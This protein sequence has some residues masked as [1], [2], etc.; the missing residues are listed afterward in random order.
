MAVMFMDPKI[1]KIYKIYFDYL[2]KDKTI[3]NV[4]FRF[5]VW[6]GERDQDWELT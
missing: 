3:Y 5:K 6:Q 1:R 2:Q 4:L